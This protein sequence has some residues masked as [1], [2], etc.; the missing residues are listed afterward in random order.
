MDF[1]DHPQSL[2]EIRANKSRNCADWTP[3]DALI[4]MLRRIDGGEQIDA[5]VICARQVNDEGTATK[6]SMATPDLITAFGLMSRA[7]WM[8][9]E[10]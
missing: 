7:M 3:R 8:M 2:S 10:A 4:D 1:K 9:N 6:F 5:L